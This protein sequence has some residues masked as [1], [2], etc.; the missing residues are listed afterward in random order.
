MSCQKRASR[1]FSACEEA[2]ARVTVTVPDTAVTT[3]AAVSL[4]AAAIRADS[5][6]IRA[7]TATSR[8]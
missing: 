2:D 7:T 3:P 8:R 4:A 6:I 5:P 1:N